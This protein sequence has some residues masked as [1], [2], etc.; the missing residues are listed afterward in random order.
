[1]SVVHIATRRQAV[2]FIFFFFRNKKKKKK[3]TTRV[4]QKKRI[5]EE[6][7]RKLWT[8]F[9]EEEEGGN[10]G[11]EIQSNKY[12]KIEKERASRT[13]PTRSSVEWCVGRRRS[14]ASSS[15]SAGPQQQHLL[16]VYLCTQPTGVFKCLRGYTAELVLSPSLIVPLSFPSISFALIRSVL[17]I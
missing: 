12:Q 11:I 14:F 10:K 16:W 7:S 17:D 4:T 15:S 13:L 9:L 1:V 2:G 6:E 5:E 3:K 8:I